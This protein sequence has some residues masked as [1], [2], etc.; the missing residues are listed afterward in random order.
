[1]TRVGSLLRACS[2]L[3][4]FGCDDEVATTPAPGAG[5]AGAE[6][7]TASTKPSKAAN[8]KGA[9]G[10]AGAP[11]TEP[12]TPLPK[13]DFQEAEFLESE[14]SRDPFR[15]FTN[16]LV[17]EER[18]DVK[19]QREVVLNEY[20][21]DEL[22]LAG[23]VTRVEP[24]AMVIDPTG[25]GHVIRRGQFIGR[26][27]MVQNAG[28]GAAYEINWRVDRIRD[29]DIVLVREDPKNPDVPTATKVIPLRPEGSIVET[30]P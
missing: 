2:W 1:M 7:T 15:A 4:L 14:R 16:L 30:K 21:I 26:P 13:P 24:R 17:E 5:G 3:L 22:K 18:K 23:I 28:R 11:S 12:T 19:S 20:G 6:A 29:G 8:K 25:K 10:S 27:E 9:K